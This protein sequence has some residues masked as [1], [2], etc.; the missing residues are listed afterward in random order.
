M[1]I[2]SLL[3][4]SMLGVWNAVQ[5]AETGPYIGLEGGVNWAS[6]QYLRQQQLDFVQMNFKKPLDS[7]YVYG[8]LV[9]W[10]FLS[11]VRT[12]LEL[13]YRKNTLSSF[14]QRYYEGNSSA[15][16]RGSEAFT[17]AFANV[18]YDIPWRLHITDNAVLRPYVGGGMGYGRLTI[19]GLAAEGV[20]FGQTHND[21]VAAWQ[22]GGG[23]IAQIGDDY[24]VSLD[25]RYLRTASA[26]Y[27]LIEGLPPQDVITHYRAESLMLGLHYN[28]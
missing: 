13:N 1:K 3:W 22:L 20:H 4:L 15:A 16:G 9:G 7:G 12:E 28:F 6:S 14:S 24:S 18:W 21:D 11:G 2:R 25:Y 27:G 17:G 19:K 5:A 10:R 23:L 26:N 8:G